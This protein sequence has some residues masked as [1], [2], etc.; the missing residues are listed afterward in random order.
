MPSCSRIRL[1]LP[2]AALLLFGCSGKVVSGLHP[3]DGGAHAPPPGPPA[4]ATNH[5][6]LFIT[7]DDVTKLRARATSS[8]PLWATG[9]APLLDKQAKAADAAR[10]ASSGDPFFATGC[11]SYGSDACEAYAELFALGGLIHPDAATRAHLQDLAHFLVL[12]VVDEYLGGTM[13]SETAD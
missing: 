5:P 8:N 10:A 4:P 6:R 11:D 1:A 7:A 13:G 9:L 12:K 3:P 2:V